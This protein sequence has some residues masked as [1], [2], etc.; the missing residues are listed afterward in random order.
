MKKPTLAKGYA[1][2]L[3]I[4]ELLKLQT[5]LSPAHDELQFIIV[6]QAFELWFK[7]ILFEL[8]ATRRAM[9]R[10]DPG[11]AVHHLRRVREIVKLLTAAFPVIETMRPHEFLEFRS[12]LR[13]ASGFQSVQF[14]EIEAL[15]GSKD[16]RYL[17]L[18]GKK[19]R[20]QLE[21]RLR[22]PSLWDAFVHLMKKHKLAT[23]SDAGILRSLV[24]V[25]QKPDRHPLGALAEALLEYDEL[26]SIWRHRHIRMT[27]RMIGGK[28]GTG[29]ASVTRLAETGY[30]TMGSGGVDYLKTTL[31]KLFFPLL[32]EARTHIRRG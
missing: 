19:S 26:F 14:R 18:F 25:I 9:E 16:R 31:D 30:S 28:P 13:P 11:R 7:L 6:H 32:W 27:M 29:Q 3:R 8:E 21:K 15:S 24:T 22:E 1:E 4:P 10:N 20:V 5:T 2:Y 17:A 23:S 12:L